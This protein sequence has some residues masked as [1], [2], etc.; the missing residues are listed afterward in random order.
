MTEEDSF[1]YEDD[2]WQP[3]PPEIA[4]SGPLANTAG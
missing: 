3:V 1:E 2:Q 4:A